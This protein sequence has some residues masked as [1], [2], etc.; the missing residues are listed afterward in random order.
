MSH[1][2]IEG[3]GH[4]ALVGTINTIVISTRVYCLGGDTLYRGTQHSD[5]G[6]VCMKPGCTCKKSS[7]W[8]ITQFLLLKAVIFCHLAMNYLDGA[9][10]ILL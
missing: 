8:I 5:T 3:W 10:V 1:I 6:A 9:V 7:S 4:L 2:V